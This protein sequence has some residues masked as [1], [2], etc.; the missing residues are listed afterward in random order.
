[1][2]KNG[3][4][5]MMVLLVVLMPLAVASVPVIT[6]IPPQTVNE[7]QL[8]QFTVTATDADNNTLG[9]SMANLPQ[10]AS[11]NSQTHQFSWTPNYN[12]AGSYTVLLSVIDGNATASQGIAIT[13]NNV[14]RA[15]AF[16]AQTMKVINENMPLQFSVVAIDPD[17]DVLTYAAPNLP[18]GASFNPSTQ[19]FAWTPTYFQSGTYTVLFS[20]SDGAATATQQVIVQVNDVSTA[21]VIT[22][23]TPSTIT[24]DY[25]TLNVSTSV[26]ATCRYDTSDRS[27]D[28]MQSFSQTSG[29]SHAKVIANL[30]DGLTTFYVKC[31]SDYGDFSSATFALTVASPPSAEVTLSPESPLKPGLVIVKLLASREMQSAPSLTYFFD[32]EPSKTHLVSLESVD[33]SL[34]L[35]RG[36]MIIESFEGLKSGTFEF[37]GRDVNGIVGNRIS[38]GKTFIVDDEKPPAPLSIKAEP[39]SNGYIRLGWYYSGEDVNSFGIYRSLSSNVDYID[40]YS[41][42]TNSTFIDSGV[43]PDTTYYYRVAAR[44]DANN[45]GELSPAAS[46][47]AITPINSTPSPVQAPPSTQRL[48]YSSM[49]EINATVKILDRAILDLQWVATSLESVEDDVQK[50]LIKQLNLIEEANS[51]KSEL[52]GYRTQLK[53]IKPQDMSEEELEQLFTTINLRL[54]KINVSV[55]KSVKIEDEQNYVQY[56]ADDKLKNVIDMYL[57]KFNLTDKEKAAYQ[58]AVLNYHANVKVTVNA[59]VVSFTSLGDTTSLKTFV[60]KEIYY[61]SPEALNT[62]AI[63]EYIPKDF[64]ASSQEL[65]I[66]TPDSEVVEQDPIFKWSKDILDYNKFAIAY[67]ID[68]KI[69]GDSIK[70]T[71]T[72]A[73]LDPNEFKLKNTNAIS[74]FFTI[75][76]SGSIWASK[77][78]LGL[79]FGFLIVCLLSGYYVYLLKIKP[80]KGVLKNKTQEEPISVMP[81]NITEE[82]APQVEPIADE[83]EKKNPFYLQDGRKINDPMSLLSELETMS[84]ETFN[85]HVN[86]QK[87]DFATWIRNVFNE[88]ELA[89]LLEQARTKEKTKDVLLRY[90]SK[91]LINNF[92]KKYK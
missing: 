37:S 84:D 8:L 52:E 91:I 3:I 21:A 70:G 67:S 45:V 11:F 7:D 46:A 75:P 1:M 62:I 55:I 72:L 71:A 43:I 32:D 87:N 57:K 90:L 49:L 12:Q 10:G 47:T 31:K 28:S 74:A 82:T 58:K 66:E 92:Q 89:D 30:P 64:A 50:S 48:P 40:Y 78:F 15:P 35:W 60:A 29:V 9:Y 19:T 22:F 59:I 42:A 4:T 2:K 18:Q 63:I 81:Q 36:Y 41:S 20:A 61:E 38:S 17:N 25:V 39:L 86:L 5:I 51:G 33:G 6:Q 44:D 79:F 27:Y 69:S 76:S 13:V 24:T 77:Q 65:S 53:A 54:K 26:N 68:K 23:N 16:I 80:K 73:L 56:L 88:K 83:Q 34:T 85:A 14:N